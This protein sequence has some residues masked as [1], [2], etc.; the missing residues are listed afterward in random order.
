[1]LSTL[2][3]R[4]NGLVLPGQE[5]ATGCC[6]V[7]LEAAS[8]V[9]CNSLAFSLRSAVRSDKTPTFLNPMCGATRLQMLAARAAGA[10]SAADARLLEASSSYQLLKVPICSRQ[11]RLRQAQ[12]R[13]SQ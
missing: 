3:C 11:L 6:H 9:L 10:A 2:L 12:L 13:K 4:L 1:M 8:V 5:A 7:K